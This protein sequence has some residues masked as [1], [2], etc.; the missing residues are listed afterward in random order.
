M[1]PTALMSIQSLQDLVLA[2]RARQHLEDVL[3]SAWLCL[4]QAALSCGQPVLDEVETVRVVTEQFHRQMPAMLSGRLRLVA[5]R[6]DWQSVP[7]DPG[8]WMGSDQPE[9]LPVVSIKA[10]LTCSNKSRIHLADS[11]QWLLD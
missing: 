3:P 8:H 7:F 1:L 5:V 9:R 4:D 10:D 11:I 2:Q 6:V